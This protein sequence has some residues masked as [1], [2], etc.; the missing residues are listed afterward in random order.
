VAARAVDQA[1]SPGVRLVVA[2]PVAA[3]AESAA[4]AT[5]EILVLVEEDPDLEGALVAGKDGREAVEGEQPDRPA[6][7]WRARVG[8]WCR[9][10]RGRLQ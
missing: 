9:R 10:R 3:A 6:G 8:S 2:D 7:S 4:E 5:G 1:I